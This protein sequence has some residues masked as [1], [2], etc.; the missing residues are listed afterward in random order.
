MR[1]PETEAATIREVGI[2]VLFVTIS[3]GPISW[4]G[5]A[6]LKTVSSL[7]DISLYDSVWL[8]ANATI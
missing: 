7:L 2:R 5:S 1:D 8:Q 6:M 3:G 4:T